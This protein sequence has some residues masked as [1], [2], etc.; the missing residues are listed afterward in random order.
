MPS[1]SPTSTKSTPASSARAAML[2]SYDVIETIFSAR[3]LRSRSSGTVTGAPVAAFAYIVESLVG[4]HRARIIPCATDR[5]QA[6]RVRHRFEIP[7][8]LAVRGD[9]SALRY[10][11]VSTGY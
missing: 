2:A 6:M 8:I 7:N 3:R 1:E 9:A 10:L 11:R 5:A 4:S